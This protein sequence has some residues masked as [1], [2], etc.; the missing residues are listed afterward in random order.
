MTD[1][2]RK[3]TSVLY[4]PAQTEVKVHRQIRVLEDTFGILL[5]KP[6]PVD[7]LEREEV[8]EPRI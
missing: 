4:L 2:I 6:H 3:M 8:N 5:L 1:C 7:H